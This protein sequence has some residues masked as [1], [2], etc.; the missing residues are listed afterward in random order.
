MVF[1]FRYFLIFNKGQTFTELHFLVTWIWRRSDH[2]V[3]FY[4]YLFLWRYK[5]FQLHWVSKYNFILFFEYRAYFYGHLKFT[6]EKRKHD[7]LVNFGNFV[8]K[9]KWPKYAMKPSKKWLKFSLVIHIEIFSTPSK[10]GYQLHT[11]TYVRGIWYWYLYYLALFA[12]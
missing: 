7:K 3:I 4:F 2:V 9:F 10:N 11:I 5:C 8:T 6:R 1:C 12:C